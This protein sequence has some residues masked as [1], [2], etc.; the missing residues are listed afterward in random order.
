[1]FEKGKKTLNKINILIQTAQGHAPLKIRLIDG[2]NLVLP[3]SGG[4]NIDDLTLD[5]ADWSTA[6]QA[7]IAAATAAS[8]SDSN[9]YKAGSLCN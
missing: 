2:I 6:K 8:L 4:S 9:I 3:S 5:G 1:M 7:T